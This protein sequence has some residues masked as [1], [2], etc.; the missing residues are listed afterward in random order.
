MNDLEKESLSK[1][2]EVENIREEMKRLRL[3]FDKNAKDQFDANKNYL[4]RIEKS[5]Q[6]SIKA[7][8]K[9]CF[10]IIDQKEKEL[11]VNC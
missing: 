1:A 4:E 3:D 11:A 5:H 7:L 8:K 9:E 10:V 6:E 2:K